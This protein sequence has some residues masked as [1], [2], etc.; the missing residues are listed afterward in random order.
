MNEMYFDTKEGIM[1][2]RMASV[3]MKEK[4]DGK[5]HEEFIMS[6]IDFLMVLLICDKDQAIEE[7]D[8]VIGKCVEGHFIFNGDIEPTP[9][10]TM[11]TMC[12]AVKNIA[13]P[14]HD[15]HQ[16]YI[17]TTLREMFAELS[18]LN[19][20]EMYRE[21][22]EQSLYI[23]KKM[24]QNRL[25]NNKFFSKDNSCIYCKLLEDITRCKCELKNFKLVQKKKEIDF[26]EKA[27]QYIRVERAMKQYTMKQYTMKQYSSLTEDVD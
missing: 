16:R 15:G 20:F 5:M 21:L 10:A 22:T 13:L 3:I 7:M 23:R 11:D 24:R 6:L 2:I 27:F 12:Y 18:D 19:S 17:I 14:T 25:N 8:S 4:T 1:V 9:F 26:F